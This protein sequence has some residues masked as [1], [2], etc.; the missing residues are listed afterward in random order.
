M[1]ELKGKAAVITGGTRGLGFGIAQAYIRAGAK[2]VVASR[3]KESVEEAVLALKE[4]G[5]E[6]GGINCDVGILEDVEGLALYTINT[7]GKFDVWVNNAG[8]SPAYGP[9]IHIP[10][11]QNE[12]VFQTNILGTYYGSLTA[13]AHFLQRGE[14]KLIN[15]SGRGDKGPVPLQNA[16]GSSKAWMRSFTLALADEYKESGVGI[17]LFKP[18][19]VDT[20]M[21]RK[22]EVIKGYE[23]RVAVLGKIIRMWGNEPETP[24]EKAVWLASPATDGKT[25]L[26]VSVFSRFQMIK[27]LV[28]EGLDRLMRRDLDEINIKITPVEPAIPLRGKK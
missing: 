1:D 11:N 15:V 12:I 23:K 4:I 18:G 22:V 26:V 6:V 9:T 24:A 2:V 27:G 14:G 25:G 16:Y 20:D 7:F 17:Y 5:G 21:L 8:L 19:I 28:S 10:H 3:S 13:M